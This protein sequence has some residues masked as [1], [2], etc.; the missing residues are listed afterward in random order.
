MRLCHIYIKLRPADDD[1]ADADKDGNG[2][3]AKNTWYVNF[4]E[5]HNFR[6]VSGESHETMRKLF[7]STK[8]PYQKIR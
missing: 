5:K 7:L 8:F 2:N 1:D 6:I 3:T 4:V